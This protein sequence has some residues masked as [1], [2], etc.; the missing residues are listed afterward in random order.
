[1]FLVYTGGIIM[2]AKAYKKAIAEDA[3]F[4]YGKAVGLGV[5]TLFFASIIMA[6]FYYILY[7]FVDPQ[8]VDQA[9]ALAE[10]ASLQMGLVKKWLNSR[11]S[12]SV[13]C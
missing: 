8:L 7:A 9:A 3:P 6:L 2:S 11:W 10:E 13:S 4:A 12:F 1:L 5:A